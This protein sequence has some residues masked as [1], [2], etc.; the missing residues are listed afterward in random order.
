MDYVI[1]WQEYTT[2]FNGDTVVMQLRPLQ[3]DGMIA[4]AP[5]MRDY[6]G[7]K[8]QVSI[9]IDAF[10]LQKLGKTIFPGHVKDIT[11]F[12]IN[13]EPP[14]SEA[15]ADEATF[16]PL[17]VD[18]VGELAIRSRMKAADEKNSVAPSGNTTKDGATEQPLRDFPAVSG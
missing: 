7:D 16:N 12:T 3:T 5:Y 10:N 8:D 9:A 15:I 11:G 17:A 13:G 18:I 2:E 1:G 6:K 14:T 4:L